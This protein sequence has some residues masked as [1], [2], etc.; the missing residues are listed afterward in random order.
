MSSWGGGSHLPVFTLSEE[1][2]FAKENSYDLEKKPAIVVA[3]LVAFGC[4]SLGADMTE[5]SLVQSGT[6]R[7]CDPTCGRAS[8][9]QSDRG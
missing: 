6:R 8:D 4:G 2:G 3:A 7:E 1:N 9:E 5:R